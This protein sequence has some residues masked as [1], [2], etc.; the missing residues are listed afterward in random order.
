MTFE[1]RRR[2]CVNRHAA[3]RSSDWLHTRFIMLSCVN[4]RRSS[5]SCKRSRSEGLCAENGHQDQHACMHG[6]TNHGVAPSTSSD[7]GT[8]VSCRALRTSWFTAAVGRGATTPSAACANPRAHVALCAQTKL[9]STAQ[10]LRQSSMVQRSH[11]HGQD[12]CSRQ[13][14]ASKETLPF[15]CDGTAAD[16]RQMVT[17]AL[18]RGCWHTLLH[19]ARA[20]LAAA[21]WQ[22]PR[23]CA[24]L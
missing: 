13:Q 8:S 5:A 2:C 4:R 21:R 15:A 17:L 3:C 7:G 9:I 24:G 14:I 12:W 18:A 11:C 20:P 1:A 22:S 6:M 23:R 16:S 19:T 10:V